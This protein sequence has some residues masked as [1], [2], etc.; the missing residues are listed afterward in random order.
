MG[1]E[2]SAKKHILAMLAVACGILA[3][4]QLTKWWALESLDDGNVIDIVWTLRFRLVFNTGS[5]FGRFQ[6]MGPLL[7]VL[8]IVLIVWLMWFMRTMRNLMG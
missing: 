3:L 4:D 2:K 6:D 5:A 7:G 1:S 8:A